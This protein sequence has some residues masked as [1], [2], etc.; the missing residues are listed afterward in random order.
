MNMK[1]TP[2]TNTFFVTE[3]GLVDLQQLLADKKLEYAQV[4]EYRKQ[5][6]ELSGDGWHD[7]PEFNRMQQ[8]EANLNHLIKELSGRLERTRCYEVQEGQRPV[9]QVSIGSVV[10][11]KRWSDDDTDPV[12]EI[13]EITGYDQTVLPQRQL[14]YN[15]PL[16]Q[17]VFGLLEGDFAEDFVVAGRVWDIEVIHL[18]PS[19][20]AAGLSG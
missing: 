16:A 11:L 14:A 10:A 19:R 5:A 18:Y 2:T 9:N 7:N 1:F 4:C 6:F 3:S 8:L 13:W 12:P 17:A 20:L 15:S